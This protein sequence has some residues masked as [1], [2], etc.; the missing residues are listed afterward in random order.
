MA[1]EMEYRLRSC[2]FD[3]LGQIKPS[4]VLDIFQDVAGWDVQVLGWGSKDLLENHGLL[5]VV[6]RTKYEM[7]A[8]VLEHSLIRAKT[9]TNVPTRFG[10]RREYLME[11][12]AGK[13]LIKSSSEWIMTDEKTRSFVSV[14]DVWPSGGDKIEKV[15]FEGRI[16]KLRDFDINGACNADNAEISSTNSPDANSPDPNSPDANS[17]NA[18]G[19]NL[20]DIQPNPYPVYAASS[21]LDCNGHVNNTYYANWIMDALNL[22]KGEQIKT[23]QIDYRKEVML[24][25]SLKIY[26]KRQA[27]KIQAK[28]MNEEGERCFNAEIELV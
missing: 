10:F 8:P 6:V 24:G 4:S 13:P 11:D 20:D 19:S 21:M 16:K 18:G 27:N 26:T 15:N 23:L 28:G 14:A 25:E 22:G 5:W 9:W 17:P 2:D 1:Y 7:L 12:S 3:A